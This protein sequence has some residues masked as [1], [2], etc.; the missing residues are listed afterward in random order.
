PRWAESVPDS[1]TKGSEDGFA[2]QANHTE[3]SGSS[4]SKPC[5]GQITTVS[6]CSPFATRGMT[7]TGLRGVLAVA[8]GASLGDRLLLMLGFAGAD[9]LTGL[10]VCCPRR[11]VRSVTCCCNA[12]T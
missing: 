4:G 3:V 10:S 6:L 12:A 11:Q 1:A 2:N 7:C 5:L 8:E 9:R